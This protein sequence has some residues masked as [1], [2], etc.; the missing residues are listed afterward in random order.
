MRGLARVRQ[1]MC[2]LTGHEWYLHFDEPKRLALRC[3]DCGR[4]TVGWDLG[5]RRYVQPSHAAKARH[6][7]SVG[8]VS[9]H[10]L[11]HVRANAK[12]SHG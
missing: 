7:R 5:R 9:L 1:L 12:V 8:G 2:G 4:I 10:L 3:I 11:P 6:L